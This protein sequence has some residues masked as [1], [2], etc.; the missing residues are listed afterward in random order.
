MI[1]QA[2]AGQ[3]AA[4]SSGDFSGG[5]QWVF[6]ARIGLDLLCVTAL[7]RVIYYRTYR[8][9]D[10]LLT[11]FAFNLTIF[12]LTFLLNG[13]Q[14]SLGAA[15]GLFAVFSILRYRTEGMSVNDM[16]YL[17][18]VIALGLIMAVSGVGLL[19]LA[20][21]GACMVLCIAVLEGNLMIRRE[22][23]RP[24]RYDRLELLRPARRRELLTDI[25]RRTGLDVR[26]VDLRE[27]DLLRDCADLVAYYYDGQ[28]LVQYETDD[29]V[30]GEL[31]AA[32]GDEFGRPLADQQV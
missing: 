5:L 25:R 24:L 8:R 31:A 21:I 32:D 30:D 10:L 14:M 23:A 11:F 29:G 9:A 20:G 2:L 18:L 6:L 17:F 1:S 28:G 7:I 12:L 15:F 3:V 27:V 26:R 16:T 22:Y 4:T 19:E 13:V